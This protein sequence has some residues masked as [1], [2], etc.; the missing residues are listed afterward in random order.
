MTNKNK[1]TLYTGVT[2]NLVHRMMEHM[3]IHLKARAKSIDQCLSIM[4]FVF[5]M[6]QSV[7]AGYRPPLGDLRFK[8]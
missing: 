7:F 8:D 5:S 2:N 3:I 1:T 4:E 6:V